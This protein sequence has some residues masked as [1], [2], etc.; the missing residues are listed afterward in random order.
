MSKPKHSRQTKRRIP[1]LLHAVVSPLAARL[2]TLMAI[3]SR[4]LFEREADKIKKDFP[5]F[6]AWPVPKNRFGIVARLGLSNRP[7]FPA[8]FR[9]LIMTRTARKRAN[10]SSSAIGTGQGAPNA[11]KPKSK[12]RRC[13]S[14]G[15][16]PIGSS[17]LLG[18]YEM[19]KM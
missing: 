4:K 14:E 7:I 19:C 10:E 3:K 11:T 8:D 17:A 9:K 6:C 13:S 1:R 2:Q 18:I 15:T 12:T 5:K 16:V